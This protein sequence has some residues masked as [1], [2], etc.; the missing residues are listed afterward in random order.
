M[1]IYI[2]ENT[3]I[4]K[5]HMGA[6]VVKETSTDII[7]FN[8]NPS[9]VEIFLLCDGTNTINDIV[10]YIEE[11]YEIDDKN[12]LYHNIATFIGEYKQKG[13]LN[14]SEYIDKKIINHI[15]NENLIIPFK[16]SL[17]LTNK[18]QLR[19]KHC[20]NLSGQA[21]ENE[22]N[23]QEFINIAKNFSTLGTQE[24][25]ITGGEAFLKPEIDKLIA[26]SA[27]N[28][29]NV[30]I[31]SNG[32]SIDEDI[33]K[34]I[35]LFPNIRI[36]ISIDGTEYNHDKIRGVKGA[37]KNSINNIKK[38]KSYNIP[39][40]IA[41]TMNYENMNDLDYVI[42]KV[43]GL[44]CQGITISSTSDTGR[45]K[46]NNMGKVIEN[47]SDI[48]LEAGKKFEDDSFSIS[49]ELCDDEI[50]I[51]ENEIPCANKC[52]AGYKII[53]IFSNG[54]ISLCPSIKNIKL[55]SIHDTIE[56]ILNYK[57]IEKA[58]NIPTP[59]K[60]ICGDCLNYKSCGKCIANM[61]NKTKEECA[62]VREL[63]I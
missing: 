37:F 26:F 29:N 23:I 24:I 1:Y 12:D 4:M 45:A 35:S 41:F 17:E 60:K 33:I 46:D 10:K 21:R 56:K 28:F 48:I 61:L 16:L 51:L 25:F 55:G 57:N 42:D 62:I 39:I 47:F 36:Q 18:C 59:N 43:K 30:T 6:L 38:I 15:G 19:C 53:H 8:I 27:K 22:I 20:F 13:I 49:R 2:N 5:N 58:M 32:Y 63:S 3:R 7:A 9:A 50:E 52:G 34:L 54:E 14:T 40:T 31:A 44:G 11:K